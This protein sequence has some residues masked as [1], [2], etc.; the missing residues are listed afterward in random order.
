M[1]EGDREKDGVKE[2]RNVD[3]EPASYGPRI[4]STD[5][6]LF[7]AEIETS[8]R[9]AISWVPLFIGPSL[10]YSPGLDYR[11]NIPPFPLSAPLDVLP[12]TT[13]SF[14]PLPSSPSCCPLYVYLSI[15]KAPLPRFLVSH[16]SA[17]HYAPPARVTSQA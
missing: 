11:F 5:C 3:Q 14:P 6:P 9:T 13:T 12:F 15:P 7:L 16:S 17:Y 2:E 8:T 1:V 4:S 10:V